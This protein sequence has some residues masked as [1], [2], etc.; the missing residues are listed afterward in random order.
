MPKEPPEG[1]IIRFPLERIKG[2]K[3]S[4]VMSVFFDTVEEQLAFEEG[5]VYLIRDYG[6]LTLRQLIDHYPNKTTR[7]VSA[8]NSLRR[9]NLILEVSPNV[10]Q[11]PEEPPDTAA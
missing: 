8:V 6:E 3:V 5:I 2:R 9:K 7:V 1:K 4:P 10:F 11:A